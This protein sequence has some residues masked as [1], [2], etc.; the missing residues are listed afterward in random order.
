MKIQYCEIYKLF[1]FPYIDFPLDT[2]SSSAQQNNSATVTTVPSTAASVASVSN[3][4]V[5]PVMSYVT[6]SVSAHVVPSTL[7]Q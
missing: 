2:N 4:V 7:T 1:N 5:L 3:N 6:S